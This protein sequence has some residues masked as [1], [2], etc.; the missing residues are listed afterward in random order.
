M[1][2]PQSISSMTIKGYNNYNKLIIRILDKI[3]VLNKC[4]KDFL[5]EI[6]ALLLCI[7]GRVN[8]LQFGR[9]GKFSE[10]RYRLQFEK[11]FSFLDFNKELVLSSGGG[12]MPLPLTRVI[13]ASRESILRDWV[14]FG[15][16]V[17]EGQSGG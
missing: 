5:C 9:F 14:I 15:Q 8:F 12:D 16:A 6:F 11:Q 13:L 10:Q 17:P 7:K 1:D 3:S 4:R 2:L